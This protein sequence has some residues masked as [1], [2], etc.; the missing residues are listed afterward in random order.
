MPAAARRCTWTSPEVG[1]QPTRAA[2]EARTRRWSIWAKRGIRIFL[3]LLALLVAWLTF[4]AP[5]NRS[6]Q[7]SEHR[8]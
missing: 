6:L 2:A 5:L 4:T 1:R 3:A 7:P 8:P